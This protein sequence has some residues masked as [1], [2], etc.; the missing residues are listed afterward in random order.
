M[1]GYLFAAL[2]QQ[3]GTV[4]CQAQPATIC[5]NGRR[6]N[7]PSFILMSDVAVI[8]I[9]CINKD[10]NVSLAYIHVFTISTHVVERV[11]SNFGTPGTHVKRESV[12]EFTRIQTQSNFN[13]KLHSQRIKYL[14]ISSIENTYWLL[15]WNHVTLPGFSRVF[16]NI[17]GKQGWSF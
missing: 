4:I 14:F 10:N 13:K 2:H 5:T 8:L 7:C 6:I 16:S 17:F 12:T 11:S 9:Y 1:R 3:Y 15:V